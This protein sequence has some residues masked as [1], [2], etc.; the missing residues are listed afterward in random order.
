MN[1]RVL[2]PCTII[3]D[4]LYVERAADRQLMDVIRDMGRPGY[5]LVA[6]QMGKT[7]LLINMKRKLAD[8]IVL[9]LDLS[10]RFDTARLWF[11]NVID[12]LV[13]SY[14]DEFESQLSRILQQRTD[15]QFEANTEYDRHLRLLLRGTDKKVVIIL[16]EIDSLVGC[17]YSDVVLAQVRSMYFSRAN[18]HEYARLTYVLSGVAEPTDLIRDKNISPFNIG[19]KIYLEDFEFSEFERF[20]ILSKIEISSEVKNRVFH[21]TNG[22][23]RMTWDV[24]ASIEDRIALGQEITV[25]TV[26]QVVNKLYLK[27]FDRA[28]VDHIRTLVASDSEIRA[29]VVSIKYGNNHFPDDKIKNKLYLAGISSSA[30][31]DDITIRNNILDEVLADRWLTQ[32]AE[33]EVS[34]SSLGSE[35]FNSRRYSDA[36]NNYEQALS[37][38]KD[39]I[40]KDAGKVLELALSYQYLGNIP[41]ALAIFGR[42]LSETK[43]FYIQQ[44]CNLYLGALML[45]TESGYDQSRIY[46]ERA[47]EGAHPLTRLNAQMTLATLIAK[48]GTEPDR[49]RALAILDQVI[50]ELPAIAAVEKDAPL[51]ACLAHYN[52]ARLLG[53]LGDLNGWRTSLD[54]ALH[55][56]PTSYHPTLLVEKLKHPLDDRERDEIFDTCIAILSDNNTTLSEFDECDLDLRKSVFSK[57]LFLINVANDSE[58]FDQLL[59]LLIRKF[60]RNKLAAYEVLL[61]LH[62]NSDDSFQKS[63]RDLLVKAAFDYAHDFRSPPSEIKFYRALA[64]KTDVPATDAWR[65]HYLNLLDRN[66]P[67]DLIEEADLEAMVDIF[68][69]HAN[70][71]NISKHMKF[72]AVYEKFSGAL[73]KHSLELVVLRRYHEMLFLGMTKDRI[74]AS[75][76]ALKLLDDI[77]KLD[78][79]SFQLPLVLPQLKKQAQALVF[80]PTPVDPFRGIGRNT[81]VLVKYEDGTIVEKKFKQV[82]GDLRNGLCFLH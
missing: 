81:K 3:P 16:D 36:I 46:L 6:R 13:D 10:N 55:I 51:A 42:V 61:D 4:A 53:V 21:W 43:D 39:F 9:Y 35:A 64:T 58:R 26:D 8:S 62:E 22:N 57:L 44:L 82:E 59:Q 20:L 19:E 11:R 54:Y 30:G 72:S 5:V 2:K 65:A 71:G 1:D 47:A 25:S 68:H 41:E 78:G 32:L 33:K 67:Q 7:N 70:G 34:F 31:G 40:L 73:A 52:K 27:D 63:P 50:H 80:K 49:L 38:D 48:T 66:C 29:A 56:S 37:E 23:P 15:A 76:V 45:G 18:Y 17:A 60:Y 28:P 69:F 79:K 74:G 75:S 12:S 77:E 24:M 14:P